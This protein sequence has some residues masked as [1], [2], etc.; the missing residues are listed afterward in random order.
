MPT[1]FDR[2]IPPI[3]FPDVKVVSTNSVK[4]IIKLNAKYTDKFGFLHIPKTGGTSVMRFLKRSAPMLDQIPI[5]LFHSWTLPL[6]QKYFP[7]MK[8]NFSIRDPLER[9]ISG[10]HSRLRMGMPEYCVPWRPEEATAFALFPTVKQFLQSLLSENDWDKSASHFMLSSLMTSRWDY[11]HFFRSPE[12]VRKA[13]SLLGNITTVEKNNQFILKLVQDN[14]IK[15]N[16]EYTLEVILEHYQREH[17]SGSSVSDVL[18][19]FDED[20]ILIMKSKMHNEYRIYNEL[21]KYK[22]T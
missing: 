8:L 22:F 12:A 13:D 1:D 14:V 19:E 18:R 9:L 20:E 10:Y 5:P 16:P 3:R 6:I 2:S 7:T 11:T 4:D 21:L 17:V 15:I